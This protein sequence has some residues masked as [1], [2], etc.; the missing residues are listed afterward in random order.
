MLSHWKTMII[1]KSCQLHKTT[2]FLSSEK[3][4]FLYPAN[5][6]PF[7]YY[8]HLK[9]SSAKYQT[10]THNNIFPFLRK[11]FFIVCRYCPFRIPWS[12]EKIFCKL[13]DT[14]IQRHFSF[15]HRKPFFFY[16][17]HMFCLC[18]TMIILKKSAA[19]YQTLTYI[20]HFSFPQKN[21]FFIVCTYWSFRYTMIS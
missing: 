20:R 4:F 16:C 17:L 19:K 3:S 11:T 14:N 1:L 8:D 13:S 15:L 6:V 10:L 7:V 5:V 21:F 12:S 18:Y 9:K 2:Y